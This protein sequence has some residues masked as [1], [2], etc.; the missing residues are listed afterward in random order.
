MLT[1]CIRGG[2]RRLPSRLNLMYIRSGLLARY[3]TIRIIHH[4]P[5]LAL[6]F[7]ACSSLY[8][9]IHHHAVIDGRLTPLVCINCISRCGCTTTRRRI[10]HLTK[11]KWPLALVPSRRLMFTACSSLY[12]IIHRHAVIDGR[13]T[14]LVCIGCTTTRRRI[15]RI[16]FIALK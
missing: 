8:R 1:F 13:L 11:C 15:S 14:P 3:A 5:M 16:K 12:R 4:H 6:V 7:T 9:I 2:C 10:S